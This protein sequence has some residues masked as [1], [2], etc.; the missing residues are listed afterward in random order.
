[1]PVFG[2]ETLG[3]GPRRSDQAARPGCPRPRWLP[4]PRRDP[5]RAG[6]VR[7]RPDRQP[8]AG[9]PS[10][11]CYRRPETRPRPPKSAKISV[12]HPCHRPT[13]ATYPT[14]PPYV[15]C[16]VPRP[17]APRR[18]EPCKVASVSGRSSSLGRFKEPRKRFTTATVGLP[19][20]FRPVNPP[21]PSE[22]PELV[23]GRSAHP[24]LQPGRLVS[25]SQE[26]ET[27]DSGATH[28]T[29]VHVPHR[30]S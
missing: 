9:G 29:C 18:A 23:G 14:Y 7:P 10:P 12:R 6:R 1:M 28:A 15:A 16:V 3:S 11:R 19:H 22:D 8:G 20:G 30:Y 24:R 21:S 2:P 25:T 13:P 4:A 27:T 5:P 26:P 17:I